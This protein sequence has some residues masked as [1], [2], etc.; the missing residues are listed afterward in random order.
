[1]NT[2]RDFLKLVSVASLAA[3]QTSVHSNPMPPTQPTQPKTDARAYWVEIAERL[4]RPMLTALSKGQ[5]KATMP[6]EIGPKSKRTDRPEVTHLE[7]VGRLLAGLSPWLE[8]GDDG[9]AEGHLRGELAALARLALAVGTDPKS[10]DFLNFTIGQ[11]PIVDTAFLAQATLR[12]PNELWTKLPAGVQTNLARCLESTRDRKPAANNWLLFAA[13]A[14]VAL[15]GMGRFWDRMRVDYALRQHA[16]WYVGDGTYGDGPNFHWDYYNSF[17]IGPMLLDILSNLQKEEDSWGLTYAQ[18]LERSRRYAQV[19]ERM[20]SPEGTFPPV[21]RSLAYRMGALQSLAHMALLN[22]LPEA[23]SPAQV[24]CALT[25][26]VHRMMDAPGTFDAKGW[27]TI[28]FCG[29]QPSI[30]E[31]Y[32]STGSTYL[33]SV[34]LLP[35]G[36]PASHPFWAAPDEPWTAVKVWGGV[37]LSP[38]HALKE[39][40]A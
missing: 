17:V 18:A 4:A 16:Q 7:A 32:I 8:L 3:F 12:A 31:D 2:R 14:E 1:M 11:Q 20:I 19:Q 23:V 30:G 26:V 27:L 39:T 37:D 21:G 22:Q 38:D 33:C 40:I 15:R 36:L 24:R 34:G 28:G 25:A 13:T 6:V 9:S 29:H 5:L 10:P 35:L